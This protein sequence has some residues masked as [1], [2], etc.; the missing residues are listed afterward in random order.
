MRIIFVRH[1]HPNYK[2]DCLTELGHKHAE[3]AADRL[4]SEKIDKF[5][6]STCGRAVET[7][8]HIAARFGATVEQLEFMREISWRAVDP[9][10]ELPHNGHPWR[11]ADAL[12]SKGEGL[13]DSDWK[14]KYPF[15]R[16]KILPSIDRVESGFDGWL[17]QFGY[18][19]EGEFYRVKG[20]NNDT[21]LLASHAGS[22]TVVMSHLFNLP[23]MLLFKAMG[24][25]YTGITVVDFRGEDGALICPDLE[26][27]N[28][29]RHIAGLTVELVF[30]N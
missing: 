24:P 20:G 12:V 15:C 13:M 5:Y 6:S 7:A 11:L 28:D 14:E 16:S 27:M 17:E 2:D 19:R 26:L 4:S 22:S 8:E 23:P 29:A 30:G 10:E 3:A 21:V 9:E 18:V 1:G 25:N